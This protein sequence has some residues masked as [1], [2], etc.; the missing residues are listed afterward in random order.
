[1]GD[2][3]LWRVSVIFVYL[4]HGKSYALNLSVNVLAYVLN[5][6]FTNSSVHTGPEPSFSFK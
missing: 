3:L 6:I 1:L 2:C 4:S 5:D